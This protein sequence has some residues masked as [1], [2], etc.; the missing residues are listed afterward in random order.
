MK[1]KLA[2]GLGI[3]ALC[4]GLGITQIQASAHP[5]NENIQIKYIDQWRAHETD[6]YKISQVDKMFVLIG[7]NED[8]EKFTTFIQSI[9]PTAEMK[10]LAL[11]AEVKTE[12]LNGWAGLW[13]RVDGQTKKPLGFDNM[14]T[15][16]IAG[17]QDWQEYQVVLDIPAETQSIS[18][19]FL[20]SGKGKAFV[21]K[22]QFKPVQTDIPVTN[23]LGH[24]P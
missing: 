11:T 3:L 9:K 15:R 1:M 23:M 4:T 16:P 19:G 20:M 5:Q 22:I 6:D 24:K 10:R 14:Q 2:I 8:P 13:M 21:R 17:T 12:S 7:S 18:L